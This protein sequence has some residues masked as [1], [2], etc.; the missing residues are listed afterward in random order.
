MHSL[1]LKYPYLT[2]VGFIF[3]QHINMLNNLI[4]KIWIICLWIASLCLV[5][6]FHIPDEDWIPS[7]NKVEINDTKNEDVEME[8]A[9]NSLMD[10]FNKASNQWNEKNIKA[11]DEINVEEWNE[12]IVENEI[13][14][15][16]NE[17]NETDNNEKINQNLEE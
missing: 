9:I 7:R 5:W 16:E 14:F 4:K 10:W 3:I 2:P 8:Q 6:C 11:N 15:N 17:E 1:K 13:D 12:D